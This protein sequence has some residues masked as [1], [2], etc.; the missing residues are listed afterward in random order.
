MNIRTATLASILTTLLFAVAAASVPAQGIDLRSEPESALGQGSGQG[1]A[2]EQGANPESFPYL[3]PGRSSKGRSHA[4]LVAKARERGL[5][6]VIVRLAV[7][8]DIPAA[9]ITRAGRAGLDAKS[10]AL[11]RRQRTIAR[12][13]QRV[14]DRL[15][16]APR[17]IKRFKFIPFAAMAADEQLLA[18]LQ[19]MPEVLDIQ[20][21][22]VN[23]ADLSSSVPHIGGDIARNLGWDG[24]GQA[25]AILDTGIDSGH[26]MLAG[27]IVAEAAACFSGTS[28]WWATSLCP[29]VLPA[30]TDASGNPISNS[31]CGIGAAEPCS[32]GCSHGTHVAG[33]AAGNGSQI[34]VAPQAGIIPVQVFVK[35]DYDN[36]NVDEVIAYDSD[37]IAGLEHVLALSAEH[38]IAAVNM[39]LGGSVQSSTAACDISDAAMKAVIDDLRA[40]GIATVIAAGNNY[41]SNGISSPACIS[42]AVSVGSTDDTDAISSFSNESAALSLHAPGSSITS[43]VPGTGTATWNGTSMATPHVAGAMAVLKQKAADLGVDVSIGNLVSA[44]QQTGAGMTEGR[45]QVP[46]IQV[47]AALEE[48]D[49]TPPVTIIVDN[50]LNSADMTVVA[51]SLSQ[52][53][54]V[55]AFGGTAHQGSSSAA[56]TI[57]FAPDLPQAGT[58]RVSAIWPVLS[59]N[60]TAIDVRIA[61]AGGSDSQFVDQTVDAGLWQDL[62][63][64]DF[65]AGTNGS[66]ELSDLAGGRVVAD[67]VRFELVASR[68][69]NSPPTA[70]FEP[71]CTDLSCTFIDASSDSDGTLVAWAWDFGDGASAQTQGAS[72]S[73]AGAGTYSVSLTVTDDDGASS[74][75][76]ADV[77]VVAPNL[78]PVA[79]FV[80][81]CA[82]LSCTFSDQSTDSDGGVVTWAW[83]F[84]DGNTSS[85]SDPTHTYAAAGSY[86]VALTVT[87][88]GGASDS[89]SATVNTNTPAEQLLQEDF[90]DGTSERLDSDRRRLGGRPITLGRRQRRAAPEHQHLRDRSGSDPATCPSPVPTLATTAARLERL[91]CRA[92]RLGS[93]DDDATGSDVPCAAT[94]TTTTASPGTSSAVTGVW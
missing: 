15:N 19:A 43:S 23:V 88:Q 64:Y 76:T 44:L 72:H 12:A 46:R 9:M 30:C 34:G 84:G 94:G 28:A 2:L 20:E 1:S 37:I 11:E 24:L 40:V 68:E 55:Y 59:G 67:A 7:D 91:P 14:S 65:D 81:S 85:G 73:Y 61:Y 48:I 69:P 17:D 32:S 92:L 62:G 74:L 45:F 27:N 89:T 75:A 8:T 78:P 77:T 3:D 36:D 87:D 80:V 39:S 83:D 70:D 53:S 26:P 33:I 18:E 51:G 5:V 47:D 93:S 42:T 21:D 82:G 22:S 57:R 41:S 66:V 6:P 50:E 63:V 29:S 52:T 90:S 25:V 54:N 16:L 49:E 58:Y 4:A 10:K 60:G 71:S 56:N 13:Q 31:A 79:D 86:T 38:N 35:Y